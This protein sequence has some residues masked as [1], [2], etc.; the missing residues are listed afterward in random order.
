NALQLLVGMTEI[1]IP[2]ASQAAP[3]VHTLAAGAP[4]DLLLHRPD[5]QAAEYRLR[6]RNADIGA[7]RAAFLP[8]ISLTG[9]VGSASAELS[10]LFESGQRAWS[11]A[12]QLT[13]PIF[14][15]GRN[16]ANLDLAHVRK[17]IAV[18]DYER[19]VQVAFREV[20]D[21]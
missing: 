16:S 7:A 11:F 18:A 8:R 21:A 13:L 20:A 3:L 5:I 15:G 19:T 9:L 1:D 2:P 6:A 4:S 17:D 10:N 14:A 12:P